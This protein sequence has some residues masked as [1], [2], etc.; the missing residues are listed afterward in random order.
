MLSALG[1]LNSVYTLTAC[2]GPQTFY[3]SNAIN[4]A[5]W[6]VFTLQEASNVPSVM[7]PTESSSPPTDQKL[8]AIPASH[9]HA[10]ETEATCPS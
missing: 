10:T 3:S 5:I 8:K 1:E 6:T 9:M 4:L 7:T 2:Q